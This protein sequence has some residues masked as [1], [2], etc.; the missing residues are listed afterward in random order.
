MEK[1]IIYFWLGTN[2][3]IDEKGA[4]ALLTKVYISLSNYLTICLSTNVTIN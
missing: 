2:A 3:S 4:A 1:Y